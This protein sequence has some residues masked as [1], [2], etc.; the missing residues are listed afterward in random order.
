VTT[1]VPNARGSSIDRSDET[2]TISLL[3]EFLLN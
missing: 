3:G 1:N 2:L